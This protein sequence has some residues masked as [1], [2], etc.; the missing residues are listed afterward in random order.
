MKQHI[1][2]QQWLDLLNEQAKSGMSVAAFCRDNHINA[3]NFYNHR[4]QAR[5]LV[6][7]SSPFSRAQLTADNQNTAVVTLRHGA[8]QLSF[9]PSVSPK[10][11]ANLMQALQ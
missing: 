8:T 6:A 2:K 7:K 1:T 5:K 11:L 10:W 3:K 4:S 9:P